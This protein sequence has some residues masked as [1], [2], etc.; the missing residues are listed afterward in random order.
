MIKWK[1]KVQGLLLDGWESTLFAEISTLDINETIK[2]N[3]TK[4]KSKTCKK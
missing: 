3:V 1:C 4:K 2:G